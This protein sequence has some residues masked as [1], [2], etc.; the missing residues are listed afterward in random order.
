LLGTVTVFKTLGTVSKNA[1]AQTPTPT[2]TPTSPTAQT[3]PAPEQAHMPSPTAPISSPPPALRTPPLYISNAA[4]T[5]PPSATWG[6]NLVARD[7]RAAFKAGQLA[8]KLL[9]KQGWV[10]N[11]PGRG[12]RPVTKEDLD[13][14]QHR[15]EQLVVAERKENRRALSAPPSPLRRPKR[16]P[17]ALATAFEGAACE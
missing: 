6:E 15:V 9:D 17:H 11:C 5:S 4:L 2:L 8:R 3:S 13:A 10:S 14:E 16:K 12:M 7:S 1:H